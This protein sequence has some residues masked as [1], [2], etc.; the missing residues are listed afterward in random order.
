MA[1]IANTAFEFKVPSDLP[2]EVLVSGKFG[3]YSDSTYSGVDASA[4]QLAVRT[5]QTANGAYADAKDYQGNAYPFKNINDWIFTEA[6]SGAVTGKPGDHTGLFAL[7]VS[8]VQKT[9]VGS[10]VY[11]VGAETLGIGLPAGE[12]GS[13]RELRVGQMY[14][15]GAGNLTTAIST[16]AYATVSSH[17]LLTP[18]ASAPTDGSVYF[19]LRGTEPFNAGSVY[20]GAGYIY[21]CARS[22]A[23]T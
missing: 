5:A 23:S 10:N 14:K 21:E 22:V 12:R 3:T 11:N 9:T 1:F 4:G 17:G 13:W 8:D 20:K 16:N 2:H 19:I 6:T 18:A 15:F 7:D